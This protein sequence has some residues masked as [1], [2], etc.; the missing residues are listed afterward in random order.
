MHEAVLEDRLGDRAYACGDGVECR[1][2][3]LHVR[4]EGRIWRGAYVDRL[5]PAAAHVH[6][7]PI[8]ARGHC[9]ARLTQLAD[10][11]IQM[12]RAGVL[13]AHVAAR[14]GARDEIRAALDPIG[15][16][17]VMRTTQPFDALNHDLVGA[18]AIDLGSHGA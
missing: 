2:L 14:D 9:R 7:D 6:F 13:D 18:R 4:G 17:V 1:E 8:I 10:D 12:L 16:H 5:R 11:R 3:R 15:Q